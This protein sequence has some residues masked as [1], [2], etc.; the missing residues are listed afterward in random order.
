MSKVQQRQKKTAKSKGKKSRKKT[1]KKTEATTGP[2]RIY[3]FA[4]EIEAR[5]TEEQLEPEEP[6]VAWVTFRLARETFALLVS[7]IQEVLRVTA[8]TRVPHAP[9]PIRGVTN[10]RSKVLPVVDL[11]LRL[12]LEQAEI[13]PQSRILVT[14]SRGRLIGLLVDS[15]LQVVHLKESGIQ[16]APPDVMTEQSYYIRGVYDPGGSLIILL[17]VDRALEIHEGAEGAATA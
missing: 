9:Y 16:P 7:H 6:T 5:E 10:R 13:T 12:S 15:V 3:S 4:D 17:D 11:R 14:A 1:A 2:H 8:I